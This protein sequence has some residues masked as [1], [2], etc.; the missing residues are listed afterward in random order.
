MTD[1][2]IHFEATTIIDGSAESIFVV[3]DEPDLLT[4]HMSEPSLMM[5][6]GSVQCKLGLRWIT[7]T[8]H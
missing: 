3:A 2:P 5:G 1:L 7:V 6:G 4:R 8:V